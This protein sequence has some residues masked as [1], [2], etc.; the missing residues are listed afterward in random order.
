MKVSKT[1]TVVLLLN[2]LHFFALHSPANAEPEKKKAGGQAESHRS[3]KGTNNT[4][5]QWKADPERGWIRAD[6]RH[7]QH[8]QNH[9]NKKQNQGKRK[10]HDK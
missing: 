5:A 4:N 8:E 7:E 10:G 9:S 3:S 6:D 2:A 1:L